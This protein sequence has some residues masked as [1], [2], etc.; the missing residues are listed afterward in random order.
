MER[1]LG[2]KAISMVLSGKATDEVAGL[3]ADKKG[4]E[5]VEES[6]GPDTDYNRYCKRYDSVVDSTGRKD[7]KFVGLRM[8]KPQFLRAAK[9]YYTLARTYE[10]R[11]DSAVKRLAD[12]EEEYDVPSPP[13]KML[14]LEAIL[15]Y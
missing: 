8:S 1:T 2:Q 14:E 15:L 6:I 11:M 13:S 5:E 7:G 10:D 9:T 3:L 4:R 12:G